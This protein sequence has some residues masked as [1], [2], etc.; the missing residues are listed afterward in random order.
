DSPYKVQVEKAAIHTKKQQVSVVKASLLPRISKSQYFQ[1]DKSNKALITL[2][3]DSLQLEE[4]DLRKF[5]ERQLLH[6]KHAYIKSDTALIEKDK[7]YQEDN[8]NKIRESP[9]Q[10]L[11]KLGQLLRVDT[12]HVQT[13]DIAYQEYSKK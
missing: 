7:P 10:Q 13:V 3:L 6:A 1:N 2:E 5:R 4:F 12:L 8:V 11:M 9:H